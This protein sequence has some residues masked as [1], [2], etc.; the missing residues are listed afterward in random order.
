MICIQAA[1]A[2][3]ALRDGASSRIYVDL[4]SARVRGIRFSAAASHLAVRER[5]GERAVLAFKLLTAL[6][7]SLT[8][9]F[10][11][12][13]GREV[14]LDHSAGLVLRNGAFELFYS[15]FQRGDLV[16]LSRHIVR[17]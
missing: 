12:L 6:A 5:E 14:R 9:R 11:L 15:S 2:P 3:V 10:E 17:L 16:G 13:V 8:G 4:L 7:Q 1:L